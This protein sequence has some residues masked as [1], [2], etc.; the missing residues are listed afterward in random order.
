LSYYPQHIIAQAESHRVAKTAQ[1]R[2]QADSVAGP[3][4]IS[5]S[6][7]LTSST[8][9]PQPQL[10][11]TSKIDNDSDDTTYEECWKREP[12]N[13]GISASSI[14]TSSSI[15]RS[16]DPIPEEGNEEYCGCCKR[17]CKCL[18]LS[19]YKSDEPSAFKIHFEDAAKPE[20]GTT[21]TSTNPDV[22][23]GMSSS[24]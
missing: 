15:S 17:Q 19:K 16:P 9:S 23:L 2:G 11:T 1:S 13:T 14:R 3:S 7:A 6:A 20:A 21:A 10:T 8:S 12:P 22:C 5:T 24:P 4:G 18:W